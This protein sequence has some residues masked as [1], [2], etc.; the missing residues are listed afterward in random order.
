M[1]KSGRKQ[2]EHA[3][4]RRREKAAKDIE[5]ESK[6]VFFVG[7]NNLDPADQEQIKAI[8]YDEYIKIERELKLPGKLKLHFK[9]YERGGREKYSVHLFL[10]FPGSK[11]IVCTQV[12]DPVR[13]DPVAEVHMLLK[14]ARTQILHKFK[15]DASFQKSYF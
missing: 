13:W 9:G 1:K 2:V 7:L 8:L 3:K 12:Y 10:D 11:P 15:T 4:E 5:I 14:K 6:N